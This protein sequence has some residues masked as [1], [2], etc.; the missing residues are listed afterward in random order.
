MRPFDAVTAASSQLLRDARARRL[1]RAIAPRDRAR[2]RAQPRALRPAHGVKCGSRDG[3]KRHEGSR[4]APFACPRERRDL[5][6]ADHIEFWN[7][8]LLRQFVRFRPHVRDDGGRCTAAARSSGPACTRGCACSTSAAASARRRCS[9]PT[10]SRRRLGRRHR[11]R[12]ADARDR[13]PDAGDPTAQA[14]VRVPSKPMRRPREFEP[15]FDLASRAS[16]RCSSRT[17]QPPCATSAR[18]SCPT[19]GCS[20]SSGD[21]TRSTRR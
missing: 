13:P 20:W 6:I 8:V 4:R 9:S 10:W 1:R 11:L 12:R 19:A 14:N 18:R 15:E 3:A 5:A 2:P 21:A 17:R 7:D 16:G